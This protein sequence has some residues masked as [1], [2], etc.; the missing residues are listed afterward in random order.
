MQSKGFWFI[1]AAIIAG[2]AG[3]IVLA[4]RSSQPPVSTQADLA[5][6]QPDDHV[7]G[8]ADASVV[9]I[10]YGDLECPACGS[11]DPF[12]ETLYSEYGDRV[13]FVFRHFP[14]SSAH[15]RAV[16]A[17]RAAEAAG[18]QGAFFEMVHLMYVQQRSWD[19]RNN[20]DL[21]PSAVFDSFAVG[22]GLDIDKFRA[23]MSDDSTLDFIN[24]QRDASRQFEVGSTPTF[25]LNGK[26]L[27]TPRSLEEFRRLLDEALTATAAG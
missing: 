9:L 15:P 23:D 16:T 19:S 22:L 27:E 24:A 14:I 11:Y 20:P 6:V 25:I 4:N 18:K 3:M 12:V 21:D 5:H 17:A 1:V 26:K 7:R 8:K 2:A 10:E 13:A